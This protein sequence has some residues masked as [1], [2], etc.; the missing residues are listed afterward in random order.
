MFA[1]TCLLSRLKLNNMSSTKISVCKSKVYKEVRKVAPTR[2][3]AECN[4]SSVLK[5]CH[6]KGRHLFAELIPQEL[7]SLM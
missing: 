5:R 6:Y 2:K 7:Q 4:C 3:C 1:A